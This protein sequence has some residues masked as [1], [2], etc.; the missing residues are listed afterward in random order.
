MKSLP[1]SIATQYERRL[2]NRNSTKCQQHNSAL[3]EL[4][5]IQLDRRAVC[6]QHSNRSKYG[7]IAC[8]SCAPVRTVAHQ[9]TVSAEEIGVIGPPAAKTFAGL[10]LIGS[11]RTWVWHTQCKSIEENLRRCPDGFEKVRRKR[12]DL[13]DFFQVDPNT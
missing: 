4:N 1:R 7:E 6:V 10:E 5:E 9:C 13:F 3:A 2:K 12:I 8:Y 11:S